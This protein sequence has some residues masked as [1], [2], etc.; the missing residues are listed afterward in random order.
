MV[1]FSSLIRENAPQLTW[2]EA[3]LVGKD[4]MI[5]NFGIN[6]VAELFICRRSPVVHISCYLVADDISPRLR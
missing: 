2:L 5:G 1:K 6:E 4:P 3:V